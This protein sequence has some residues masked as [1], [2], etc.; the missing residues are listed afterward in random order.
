MAPSFGTVTRG[1]LLPN[2]AY[3][4]GVTAAPQP[5]RPVRRALPLQRKPPQ[6]A[7]AAAA[8]PNDIN[9]RFGRRLRELRHSRSLT[10][11]DMARK[12][13]IDR[14]FISEIECGRKAIS[15]PMIEVIALGLQIS[16]S[17]LLQGI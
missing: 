9:S 5:L 17:E 15:L 3:W 12:F 13:G 16:L 8:L 10:Q 2:S 7:D 11:A 1:S 4:T 14:S 6:P